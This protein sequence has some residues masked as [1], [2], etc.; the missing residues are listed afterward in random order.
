MKVSEGKAKA[1]F[2]PQYYYCHRAHSTSV[3]L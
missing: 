2:H 3:R 1:Y